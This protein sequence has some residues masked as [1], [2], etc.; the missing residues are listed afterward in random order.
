[1]AIKQVM[2]LT[3]LAILSILHRVFGAW[4]RVSGFGFRVS[5]FGFRVSGVGFRGLGFRV[6]SL[7][8]KS[9]EVLIG[10]RVGFEV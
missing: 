4:F 2:G 7:R 1:L 10:F 6:K 9:A 8:E 3:L 5:G